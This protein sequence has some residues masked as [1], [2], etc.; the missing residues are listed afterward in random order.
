MKPTRKTAI[1]AAA[2]AVLGVGAWSGVAAA[3]S[4]DGD[5]DVTGTDADAAK[6]AALV[7]TGGGHVNAV[8]RDGEAGATW[9]VEV[10]K[11]NGTTVDVRLDENFQL[12]VIDGDSEEDGSD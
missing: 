1:T 11:R 5:A 4:D 2:A 3:T 12:V 10:T 7:A 8:E 9:E 6:K